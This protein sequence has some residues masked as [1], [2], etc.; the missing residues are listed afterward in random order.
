M[1]DF[2]FTGGNSTGPLLCT[3]SGRYYCKEFRTIPD[4]T[5]ASLKRG[6]G[7]RSSFN[8]NVVTVFGATGFVGRAL[9]NH[10]GKRGAQ[11][12]IPYRCDSDDLILKGLKL[13]GDLGQVLFQPFDLRDPLTIHKAVKYSNVV[14]N[15]IGRFFETK[16]FDH[17]S[18]H[19]KGAKDIAKACK[20]H[21]VER[22][23]HV[24]ALN[25]TENPQKYFLK[26][27]N[28]Y[29]MKLKGE[30]AVLNE[31]PDATI[32]RPSCVYG[33]LDNFLWSLLY[34]LR[35]RGQK[36]P[37]YAKGEK[38]IK[39]PVYIRDLVIGLINAINDFDTRGKIYQAVGPERYYLSDI[40]TYCSQILQ[41]EIIKRELTCDIKY[42]ISFLLKYI[43]RNQMMGF[44]HS[45]PKYGLHLD[46]IEIEST[47]D[48][49]QSNLP[50]LR[51]LGVPLS[52]FE[53]MV[54]SIILPSFLHKPYQTRSLQSYCAA[55]S[56]SNKEVKTYGF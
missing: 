12:I 14:V 50:T 42:D 54:P 43:L 40:A 29:A 52:K 33:I 37:L 5:L 47:T 7:G 13:T 22:L 34:P 27:N 39:Q 15:L 10:L 18:V 11:M 3:I 38:T 51:D 4:P 46:Y 9:C 45:H 32:I 20:E 17:Y 44:F 56:L 1:E 30:E 55:D 31:F 28:Y 6:T 23:I 21:N 36:I 24:S 2:Y 26:K 48:V 41:K 16:N 53:E 19:V 49:V 35:R 8:G 25:V